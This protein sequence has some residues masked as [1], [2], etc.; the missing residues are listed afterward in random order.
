MKKAFPK[1]NAFLFLP[2][3]K[4]MLEAFKQYLFTKCGY[5]PGKRV[6]LTVS[7]GIDSMVMWQLF[8][9][10]EI[11]YGIAHCNFKLR[12]PESDADAQFVVSHA[13]RLGIPCFTTTFDTDAYA[14]ERKISIQMAA[15][16]LRY[17]WFEKTRQ[18]Y[19]YQFI[20]TAH[21]QN[22]VAETFLINA[23]R[24]SG[25]KGLTGIKP[26]SGKYLIRPLLFASRHSIAEFVAL[27][28]INFRED[29][30]NASIKYT[31]N[32]IRHKILPLLQE[33]NPSIV[34]T[35]FETAN[36]LADTEML[37]NLM[38]NDFKNK[39][40]E[41][42]EKET[43]ISLDKLNALESKSAFLYFALYEFGFNGA[44][45]EDISRDMQNE[46]GKIYYSPTHRLL[47]DRTMLIVRTIPAVSSAS[48]NYYIEK[49]TENTIE[50]LRLTFQQIDYNGNF[51]L[52]TEKNIALLNA[53]SIEY[54][55]LIRKWKQGDYF[56]PLGMPH[57]VKLSDYFIN[58]KFTL[59]EKEDV[60]LLC[61]GSK[62]VWI[63]GQRIDDRFKITNNTIAILKVIWE[64]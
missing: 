60:W 51:D 36:K 58:Q 47:R 41:N 39:F 25:L 13:D 50:P 54:P 10:S 18:K 63:I 15:R 38:F 32:K 55:L 14:C 40:I 1:R 2:K 34:Q 52:H 49:V 8:E 9:Q 7:G 12:G 26:L 20:A 28:N 21:N 16:D 62:I 30:S 59:F 11:P 57:F 43:I 37:F 4:I 5:Q 6:L 23:S 61:S 64:L 22:D 42:N 31:R 19:D 45:I 33:I 56:M 24:G 29:A 17:E 44:Q 3:V 48:H 46:S 27:N 53:N 35:L